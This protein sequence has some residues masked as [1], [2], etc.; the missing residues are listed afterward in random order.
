MISIG[1]VVAGDAA[2]GAATKSGPLRSRV[3]TRAPRPARRQSAPVDRTAS[4]GCAARR[5]GNRRCPGWPE[6]NWWLLSPARTRA[7]V[8]GQ[9][10]DAVADHQRL[11]DRMGHEQQREGGVVPQFEQ[12]LLHAA[13]G[14]RV[15]RGEGLVHQQ[16]L[17]PHRRARGQSPRAVSCRRRA[18]AG[19]HRR[20][21]PAPPCSRKCSATS[22]ASAAPMPRE[23]RS[24]N[25]TFC[26][27]GLPRRQLVEFLEHDDAVRPRR[28]HALPLPGG[29]RSSAGGIEAR[30]GL[31]AAW[32]CAAAGRAQQHEA[33]T[34]VHVEAHAV[35]GA[36]HAR[37][38]AVFERDAIHL[39][40][41]RLR[42][43]ARNHAQMRASVQRFT[44]CQLPWAVAG[45]RKK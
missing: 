1:D 16:H 37:V 36:H 32:I 18:C 15:Q 45:S 20:T 2:P 38:G 22:A 7:R 35:R 34:A 40:Q 43:P 3:A 8:R 11:L 6:L 9:Q 13:P 44:T 5:P 27:T 4:G 28:R 31:R 19:R 24:G 17:G 21:A 30:Y 42:R 41:R 26:F 14:Q 23:R 29:S 12:F 39:Q 25:I 33:V 10:Q